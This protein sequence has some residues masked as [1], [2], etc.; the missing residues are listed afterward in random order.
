MDFWHG[1]LLVFTCSN[2]LNY[3]FGEG[4]GYFL[5]SEHRGDF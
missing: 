2:G 5:I 4:E 1:E 3:K